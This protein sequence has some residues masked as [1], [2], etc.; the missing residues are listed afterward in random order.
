MLY[1]SSLDSRLGYQRF[2]IDTP[3]LKQFGNRLLN[4]V[5]WTGGPSRYPDPHFT[6]GQ[7]SL[8]SFLLL[9][10]LVVMLDLIG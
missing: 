7:P 1:R 9:G 10:M 4:H 5:V 3:K 8:R 6:L 2:H